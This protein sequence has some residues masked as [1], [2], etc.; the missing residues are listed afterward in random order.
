MKIYHVSKAVVAENSDGEKVNVRPRVFRG[1]A[2]D[3]K[4]KVKF[5][6]TFPLKPIK[7]CSECQTYEAQTVD[8]R[9]NYCADRPT[10]GMPEPPYRRDEDYPDPNNR[11]PTP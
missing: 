4:E 5:R 7:L 6:L 1:V 10:A 11:P 2:Y 8:D 3:D 9:C